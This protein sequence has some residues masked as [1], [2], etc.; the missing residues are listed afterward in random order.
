[1]E[2]PPLAS[3]SL[4]HVHYNPNDPISFLSAWLALV[5]QGLCV[6]YVTLIW[7]SRE[8]EILLMFAGQIACEAL[9][10]G[11]KRLIR[12][13]RPRQMYGKGYG[14]PSSH[15][16]FAAFFSVSL[17]LFLLFRHAPT[18]STSYS[19]STFSE[20]LLLSLLACMG[21]GAVAASR[22]YLNY[23]TPKQVWAGALGGA[24]F[25]VIWFL[26]TTYL[27]RFGWVDWGLETW[28]SRKLRM[29]D[30]ISTEDIQ[31]A[32]WERW[33]SRRKA[34]RDITSSEESKKTR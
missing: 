8:V 23:H 30:L 2:D 16:Q 6:I 34:R 21:A 32:G 13:E 33:E 11:L 27:R 22:V 7:A 4:T 29:R 9:N 25:A 20:R 17:S 26:F 5:P 31:D 1:M 28:L 15:S 18:P 10:F 12:E 19:P 24:C 3:L 14:M